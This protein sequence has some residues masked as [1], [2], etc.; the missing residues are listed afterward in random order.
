VKFMIMRGAEFKGEIEFESDVVD[1]LDT[2]GEVLYTHPPK[3][4][5]A[6]KLGEGQSISNVRCR[7]CVCRRRN[8]SSTGGSIAF[9]PITRVWRN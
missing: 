7:I 3:L 1:S 4:I 6:A 5:V 8:S 9:V 2:N